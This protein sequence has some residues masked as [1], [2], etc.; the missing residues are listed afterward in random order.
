M[1]TELGA[2]LG[3]LRAPVRLDYG[4]LVNRAFAVMVFC[5]A[6]AIVEPSPYD[7]ASLFA[8]GFWILGGFR[9][10]PLGL[11]FAALIFVYNLGGF[12][13]LVPHLD[14]DLPTTFMLQSLYLAMTAIF[15]VLFFAQDTERRAEIALKGF[16]LSTVLAASCGILGY[17]DVAGAGALFTLNDRAS[18]TFKDPNVLGSYL[19]M[20]AL[21]FLQT[22]LLAR[23]RRP[24]WTGLALVIVMAGIFLSFSRGSWLAFAVA[25]TLMVGLTIATA[26][27]DALRRRSAAL[28]GTVALVG[29]A[30]IGLLL[31][32]TDVREFFLQRFALT[33][34]Y[35]V[36][37][38]GRF[39]NQLRSLG[40]LLDRVN[41]FGPLRFRLTFGLDPHNSFINAFA[42]YGWLGATAFFLLVGLTIFIGFRLVVMPSPYRRLAQV[43]WPALL[44]FLLQGLQ[45]DIDHWRHVYLM[46]GAVWGLE[47]ARL[48]WQGGRSPVHA[49]QTSFSRSS[50]GIEPATRLP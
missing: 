48:R 47:T 10:H 42:S 6:I 37:E 49:A 26:P 4:T 34:E 9:V 3:A 11:L 16:A 18:G 38:T 1:P 30:V 17:F 20:G 44:V 21:Y 46:L 19:I 39:G 35:D 14:E 13:S 29:I 27:T 50:A 5:G 32:I 41:G 15:F 31:S 40:M 28:A 25:V 33:Q 23:T 7:F 36:G 8:L 2:P 24:M 45:I 22:L 12:V 43:Y